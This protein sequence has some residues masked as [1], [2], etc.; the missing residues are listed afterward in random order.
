MKNL[1]EQTPGWP[2]PAAA[3]GGPQGCESA[4]GCGSIGDPVP[5]S[6]ALPARAVVADDGEAI[7]LTLYRGAEA[8]GEAEL[9]PVRAVMLAADLLLAARVR[10]TRQTFDEETR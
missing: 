1:R 2:V 7:R 10:L 3:Q 5:A 4:A 8:L 9:D 6:P